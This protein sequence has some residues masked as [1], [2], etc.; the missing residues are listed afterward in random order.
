MSHGQ[1]LKQALLGLA[2]TVVVTATLSLWGCGGNS[3]SISDT[4][5]GGWAW[6]VPANFPTPRVPADNPM[7]AAEL[8]TRVNDC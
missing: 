7:T 6:S 3:V 2:G 5:Q 4:T 1:R 8:N